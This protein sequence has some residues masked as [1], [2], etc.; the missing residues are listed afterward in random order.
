MA[1]VIRGHALR[2][3]QY[4]LARVYEADAASVNKGEMLD[5]EGKVIEKTNST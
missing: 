2:S 3:N 4:L 5:A 1:K